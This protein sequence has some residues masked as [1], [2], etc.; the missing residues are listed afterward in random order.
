MRLPLQPYCRETSKP[1]SPKR[2]EFCQIVSESFFFLGLHFFFLYLTAFFP[3]SD[4]I[5]NATYFNFKTVCRQDV[6]LCKEGKRLTNPN[7][8]GEYY[9]YFA[10]LLQL[11]PYAWNKTFPIKLHFCTKLTNKTHLYL[12][13]TCV[14]VISFLKETIEI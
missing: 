8:T 3:F 6:V 2:L 12:Y 13:V 5:W 9:K 14:N 10:S 4:Y 7:Q 1:P 11:S